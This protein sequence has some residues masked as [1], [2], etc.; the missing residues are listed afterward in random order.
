MSRRYRLY[1]AIVE[2]H[3]KGLRQM[4]FLAG[5]RQVGKTTVARKAADVYLDWDLSTD[6]HLIVSGP[7]AVAEHAG[8]NQLRQHIPV[9][10]FDELHKFGGWKNW[11]KGFFDGH[12]ERSRVIVTGSSRLDVIR[13]GGD[14][15]MGRYFLYHMHPL[16]VAELLKVTVPGA[17]LVRPP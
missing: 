14:S 12:A 1:D 4:V 7:N 9:V 5:P 2:Q 8:L 17:K 6:Q 11:L 3:L 15:L 16:S 10:A 13:R